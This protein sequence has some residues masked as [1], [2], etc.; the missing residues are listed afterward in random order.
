MSSDKS[1]GMESDGAATGPRP[2]SPGETV[3]LMKDLRKTLRWRR[4]KIGWRE[5]HDTIM[6]FGFVFLILFI[7][8]FLMA[9]EYPP[10]EN[11]DNDVDQDSEDRD[12]GDN[13]FDEQTLRSLILIC[14]LLVFWII[15]LGS[16]IGITLISS[17]QKNDIEYFQP[18]LINRRGLMEWNMK[19]QIPIVSIGLTILILLFSPHIVY[20]QFD[21][22]STFSVMVS[23][24]IIIWSLQVLS[25][26]SYH[27]DRKA[28]AGADEL[29]TKS[30]SWNRY[31]IIVLFLSFVHPFFL[32]VLAP[33]PWLI[34]LL[35][36]FGY[37]TY[38]IWNNSVT[39]DDID[40]W[41]DVFLQQSEN[42]PN[43][44]RS[45]S[46]DIMATKDRILETDSQLQENGLKEGITKEWWEKWIFDRSRYSMSEEGY[47]LDALDDLSR[48]MYERRSFTLPK[49]LFILMILAIL[50]SFF[51]SEDTVGITTLFAGW[52]FILYY[53]FPLI[54]GYGIRSETIYLL[55][56][57]GKTL[58]LNMYNYFVKGII[59]L[60]L[61]TI[62][63]Q[64]AF[65]D[66]GNP[67]SVEIV[68]F[69]PLMIL[70]LLSWI[71]FMFY[72][73]MKYGNESQVAKLKNDDNFD[74]KEMVITFGYLIVSLLV[75][76]FG[77]L[78]A[79]IIFGL[80]SWITLSYFAI[81]CIILILLTRF[82]LRRSIEMYDQ[83]SIVR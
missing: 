80:L 18:S 44:R 39:T 55:P 59:I 53:L 11:Q 37:V 6:L 21:P 75:L 65:I 27:I 10:F 67:P 47:G 78:I 58:I 20:D 82:F 42:P 1:S 43:R 46:S 30:T 22:L 61:I 31:V 49:Y 50:V 23:N 25:V 79:S 77:F 15:I 13:G 29:L 63:C 34:I 81:D 8:M 35:L 17:S 62:F 45:R 26:L 70:W 71:T 16:F 33:F 72:S 40:H 48:I 54:G 28:I 3:E 76:N 32:L 9:N 7:L 4:L 60:F 12:A 19:K 69:L 66:H 51:I 57:S 64:Y 36:P 24:C 68:L 38:R 41:F 74:I 73:G 83:I 14:Y 5:N 56:I 2:L 52:A